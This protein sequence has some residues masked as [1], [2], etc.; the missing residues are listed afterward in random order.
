MRLRDTIALTLPSFFLRLVLGITFLWAGTGKL[1]GTMQVSGDDAARLA[2][3]G[4]VLNPVTPPALADPQVEDPELVDPEPTSP[5]PDLTDEPETPLDAVEDGV[6]DTMTDLQEQANEV[7]KKIEEATETPTPPS[8]GGDE[9]TNEAGVE[10]IGF[11]PMLDA[12][13]V[14]V[15]NT[16]GDRAASDFPDPM[17]C[18][19]LYSIALMISKAA[20]PGLTEDSQPITPI[21]PPKLATGNW[22]KLMAWAAAITELA[23]GGLLILGLLTRLSALG[24]L[25]VMLVAMWMT[26]FG[27]A[28]FHT[29]DAI[30]GFIPRADDLFS[31]AA[32]GQLLW[33]LALASMSLA[34]VFLG[35][36]AIGL[37]R[38]IFSSH[39]RDPYLHGDPKA[40][41]KQA[42]NPASAQRTEFDRSPPTHS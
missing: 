20:D 14:R 33:Q 2:N 37:D 29:N 3:M 23:A 13:I 4:V 15:Q 12:R 16:T 36:G 6:E 27:H 19:R 38:L 22:P 41:K 31:P 11:N 9:S 24:T 21:M 26:Q 34:V 18:Q 40:G 35:S 8:T 42:M 30:L 32:Y 25:S 1:M 7:I 5:L 10:S 17:E 39:P 28:A